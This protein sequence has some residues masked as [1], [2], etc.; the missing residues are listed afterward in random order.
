MRSLQNLI[1][2]YPKASPQEKKEI[3][4]K[5]LKILTLLSDIEQD[6]WLDRI[7]KETGIRKTTLRKYLKEEKN[8]KKETNK[9]DLFLKDVIIF[10]PGLDFQRNVLFFGFRTYSLNDGGLQESDFYTICTED[11]IKLTTDKFELFSTTFIPEKRRRLLI[12]SQNC[13]KI[14][15][16]L[17]FLDGRFDLKPICEIYQKI[18][19]LLKKFIYFEKEEHYH[20]VTAWI[21][22]TFFYI[23]FD[24]F[25]YLFFSGYKASGKTKVLSLLEKLCFNAVKAKVTLGALTDTADA[26]RGTLLLDQCETLHNTP[27]LVTF[28]AD[29]YKKTCGKRR[30]ILTHDERKIAEYETYCPKAFASTRALPEDLADRVIEIQMLRNVALPDLDDLDETQVFNLK[31]NL[32]FHLLKNWAL[33]K[34]AYKNTSC[35][36][37]GRIKELW[38]PLLAIYKVCDL[39][40]EKV[41]T[42][43]TEFVNLISQNQISLPY[44][45]EVIYQAILELAQD[46]NVLEITASEIQQKI[47]ELDSDI[48]ISTD[49]IGRIL[50]SQK[51]GVKTDR[52]IG[53]RR[54][55]EID[56]ARIRKIIDT[57]NLSDQVA[58]TEKNDKTSDDYDLPL[59]KTPSGISGYVAMP[60]TSSGNFASYKIVSGKEQD[61]ENSTNFD[62]VC[63]LATWSEGDKNKKKKI[64]KEQGRLFLYDL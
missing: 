39:E 33:I 3:V 41:K 52:R 53:N 50:K 35:N 38:R 59:A 56:V 23:L 6:I 5:I 54:I 13:F 44:R 29:G 46:E 17:A 32:Y 27:E 2:E 4:D 30:L 11:E 19:A 40:E 14:N 28:L 36:F 63:H 45:V 37:Q 49:S 42:T 34:D 61:T 21:I 16:F 55:W 24:C 60:A 22:G 62:G 9:K 57:Y 1:C 47:T 31:Q 8:K 51:V 7:S 25:P 10:H 64:V 20:L 58:K 12:N 15:D 48:N 43:E 18:F 26:L